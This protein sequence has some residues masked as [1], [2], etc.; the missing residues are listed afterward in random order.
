MHKENRMR[1]AIAATAIALLASSC[2]T[3]VYTMKADVYHPAYE[4]A[5][6]DRTLTVL[7]TAVDYSG[8]HSNLDLRGAVKVNGRDLFGSYLTQD[9]SADLGAFGVLDTNIF[10]LAKVDKGAIADAATAQ[11]VNYLQGKQDYKL[12]FFKGLGEGNY[13]TLSNRPLGLKSPKDPQSEV[14]AGDGIAPYFTQVSAGTD[15]S[16]S[17]LTLVATLHVVSEAVEILKAPDPSPSMTMEEMQKQPKVG[18]YW[19]RVDAYLDFS[20]KDKAGNVIVSDKTKRDFPI[21]DIVHTIY[22]LPVKHGDGD[23]FYKYLRTLDLLPYAKKATDNYMATMMPLVSP[24]YVNTLKMT[25]V[26]SK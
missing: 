5:V 20:L 23:G 3:F 4:K 22:K 7:P 6:K 15:G 21:K 10:E 14:Y 18:E 13:G 2:G 25:E 26:K 1:S 17:D 8:M 16:G 24:F 9:A 11:L 19:L 12:P